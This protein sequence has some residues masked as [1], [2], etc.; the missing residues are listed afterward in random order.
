MSRPTAR[1]R[2]AR[3]LGRWAEAL[4][5]CLLLVKG[6]AILARGHVTG[7]GTGAGEI[8]IVARRG[9]TVVFV[10]VKARPDTDQAAAAVSPR[11]QRRLAK[12]ADAFLA[13]RP[14]LA[15]CRVRFDAMLVSPWRLPRH[16]IDA[17]RSEE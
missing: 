12:A 16:L 13:R 2:A 17:W 7:R 9:A 8:D 14:A 6:Y 10:E 4:C 15:G 3:R 11:Q 5:A 1:R